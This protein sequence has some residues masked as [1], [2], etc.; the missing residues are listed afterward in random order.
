MSYGGNN[1]A[2]LQPWF[3]PLLSQPGLVNRLPKMRYDV[4]K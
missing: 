2:I 4:K 1:G 3:T